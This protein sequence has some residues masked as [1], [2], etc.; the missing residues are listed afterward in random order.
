M[1]V[2]MTRRLAASFVP[3]F[4]L[5]FGTV[6]EANPLLMIGGSAEPAAD[7][8]VPYVF[9]PATLVRDADS[10]VFQAENLPPWASFDS[11]KGTLSGVP[12][13]GDVGI[14]ANI[15]ISIVSG[16]VR[17]TMPEFSITVASPPAD[18][19]AFLSW[20]PPQ[21]NTDSTSYLN[22]KGYVIYVGSSP[23]DMYPHL[24]VF[25]SQ[26]TALHVSGLPA[27]PVYLAVTAF[28]ALGEQSDY[29]AIAYAV[30]K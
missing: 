8:G 7:V 28:N 13:P 20:T 16:A 1:L 3:I 5:Q 26:N 27:G 18:K 12:G 14:Y 21:F 2:A 6:A 19:S 9:L 23:A 22:P 11:T 17:A 25:N 15:R 30:L 10:H 4:F 24:Y 29:S